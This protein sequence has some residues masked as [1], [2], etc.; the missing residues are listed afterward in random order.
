[1]AGY[2]QRADVFAEGKV[3][4]GTVFSSLPPPPPLPLHRFNQLHFLIFLT[5]L[6]DIPKTPLTSINQIFHPSLVI[7][8]QDK[9]GFLSKFST[10]F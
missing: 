5:L 1:M 9:V 3:K 2:E 6:L 7:F 10:S 4:E 8:P